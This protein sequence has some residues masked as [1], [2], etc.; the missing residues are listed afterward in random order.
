MTFS[1]TVDRRGV[2]GNIKYAYGTYTNA[3]G[4]TGGDIYTGLNRVDYFELIPNSATVI[5]TGCV[6]NETL[7]ALAQENVTIKTADDEDGYW[8]AE[9]R[10]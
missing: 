7:P 1:Y 8:Y 2:K 3:G 6:V 9:G 10:S 5:A 4:D